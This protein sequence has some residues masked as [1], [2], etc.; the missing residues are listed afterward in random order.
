M[1]LRVRGF[2][3][4]VG[5]AV[6]SLSRQSVGAVVGVVAVG[7]LIAAVVLARGCS[8]S[9]FTVTGLAATEAGTA[10]AV[11]G[12]VIVEAAEAKVTVP[13][14]VVYVSGAVA[15]PGVYELDVGSRLVDCVEQAGGLL[16]EANSASINLA[17]LLRDGEHIIVPA[18][19][20]PAVPVATATAMQTSTS[21]L[22]SINGATAAEL[23][24][25][26]GIGEVLAARIIAYREKV[27]GFTSLRQ[28]LS[29]SGI[30]EKRYDAIKDH[31][32]L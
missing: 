21:G 24:T 11:T 13:T 22:V 16:P 17:A 23:C 31:I 14:I 12:E 2:V 8:A 26:D 28:L 30:G 19:G 15:R 7:A 3:R 9:A 10:D 6:T 5:A 18:V 27:G 29:V 4:R 1:D 32:C 20:D 25:L